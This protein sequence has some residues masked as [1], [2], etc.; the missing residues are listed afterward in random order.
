VVF[1]STGYLWKA[2]ENGLLNNMTSDISEV[3]TDDEAIQNKA[4]KL[5]KKFRRSKHKYNF[6]ASMYAI[7]ELFN[8]AI[9]IMIMFAIDLLMKHR[10]HN[11]VPTLIQY[12]LLS[13]EEKLKNHN[14]ADIVFPKVAKCTWKQYSTAGQIDVSKE[15][16]YIMMKQ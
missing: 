4:E 11:Y 3:E 15:Y 16:S 12:Y 14:P 8:L 5:T 13:A 2:I 7:L 10:F 9:A 6:Y 1:S